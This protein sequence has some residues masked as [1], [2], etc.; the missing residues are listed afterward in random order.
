MLQYMYWEKCNV[1]NETNFLL[2]LNILNV[3][4]TNIFLLNVRQILGFSLSLLG[5]CI[6]S[7]KKTS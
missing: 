3:A 1:F 7:L 5:Q 6:Y 2:I 4:L